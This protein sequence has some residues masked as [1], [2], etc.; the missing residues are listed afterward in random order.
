[1]KKFFIFSV[2]SILMAPSLMAHTPLVEG[3]LKNGTYLPDYKGY[4]ERAKSLPQPERVSY[5]LDVYHEML[6]ILAP[7]IRNLTTAKQM[8]S[9]YP[10]EQEISRLIEE[11]R[12]FFDNVGTAN[13][14]KVA[15]A[16]KG[17]CAA[18]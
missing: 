2:L 14:T 5:I 3:A 17:S 18:K 15:D 16:Q 12:G 11:R 10:H 8:L 4:C 1:M 13:R 6:D 7:H 9:K